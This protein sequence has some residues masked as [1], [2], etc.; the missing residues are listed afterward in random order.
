[1]IIDFIG[2]GD[3]FN[4]DGSPT[5]QSLDRRKETLGS[6]LNISN[7]IS[8]SLLLAPHPGPTLSLPFPFSNLQAR[9]SISSS[10][11]AVLVV[12]DSPF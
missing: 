10:L 9:L 5:N 11:A 3:R 7:R 2:F 1:M 8:L 6:P 12:V 4:K